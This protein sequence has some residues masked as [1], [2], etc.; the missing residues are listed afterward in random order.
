MT[1]KLI[2]GQALSLLFVVDDNHSGRESWES[3]TN[4]TNMTIKMDPVGVSKQSVPAESLVLL[5]LL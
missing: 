4:T 2:F 3:N 5:P 1:A